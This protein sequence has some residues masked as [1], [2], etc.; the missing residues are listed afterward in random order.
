[1]PLQHALHSA[2]RNSHRRIAQLALGKRGREPRGQQN[3]IPFAKWQVKVI[4]EH[5]H[6]V[7]RGGRSAAFDEAEMAL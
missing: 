6:H 4:A 2:T 1:M 7:A 3:H 5:L